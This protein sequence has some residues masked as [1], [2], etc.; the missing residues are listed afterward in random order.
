MEIISLFCDC[1]VKA[2]SKVIISQ[3]TFTEYEWAVKKN[4]GKVVNAFR[5][6]ELD[7]I[8]ETET[9]TDKIDSKTSLIIICNPNN[10]NGALDK[11]KTIK[12]ITSIACKKNILVLLDEAFI[13]FTGEKNSLVPEVLNF[14]N[15]L[16]SRSFTKFFGI[17]GLRIGYG[18]SNS[19]I[20]DVM[21][22]N[23]ELW[24]V[25]CIAQNVA[26]YLINSHNLIQESIRFF[27]KERSRLMDSFSQ[28]T[29]IKTYPSKSN[30]L[31]L[32]IKDTKLSSSK[33]KEL[34]L[35]QNIL[36]R[37]CSTFTGLDNKYIRVCVK[38][39]ELNQLLI[40]KFKHYLLHQMH[41]KGKNLIN[42]A[43][44]QRKSRGT[45]ESCKYFPCHKSLK[46]CTFCYCPFY[47]CY[48][49]KSGGEEIISKSMNKPVWSCSKC[50][51][52]HNL[53]YVEKILTGILRLGTKIEEIPKYKLI[54]LLSSLLG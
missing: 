37:D 26:K 52:S 49:D 5:K 29:G 42:K 46:D 31:L 21:H 20:I 23:K 15:L 17:P 39:N 18:V 16:I 36:I 19:R 8:L 3:P 41:E 22:N 54:E 38:S 33:L 48:Y 50:L 6:E 53:V 7:F 2:G 44:K 32:N 28:I 10:P 24:S 25:N 35:K 47:P 12:D 34:L 4:N 30:F 51:I 27:R 14:D 11:K 9:I 45:H 13:D 43:L 40:K 1:V